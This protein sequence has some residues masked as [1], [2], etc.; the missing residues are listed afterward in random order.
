MPRPRIYKNNA[1]RQ[2]AYR[3]RLK[4]GLVRPQETRDDAVVRRTMAEY[5]R[6]EGA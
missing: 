1:A 6:A 5:R 2:A 4:K 3:K